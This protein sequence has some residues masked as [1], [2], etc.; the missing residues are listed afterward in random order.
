MSILR[1]Y[2]SLATIPTDRLTRQAFEMNLLLEN[3]GNWY[4]DLKEIL[5]TLNKEHNLINPETINLS[6]A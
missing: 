5:C 3:N 2:N 6:Y 1:L 4:S